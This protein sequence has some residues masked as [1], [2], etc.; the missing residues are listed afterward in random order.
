MALGRRIQ[1]AGW[2]PRGAWRC[3]A[4]CCSYLD[5]L[6]GLS[7]SPVS[8]LEPSWSDSEQREDLDRHHV[9]PQ[10]ISM[11]LAD[12]ADDCPGL[13]Q[14]P[15]TAGEA[16]QEVCELWAGLVLAWLLLLGEE[17]SHAL[18]SE[19]S[20]GLCWQQGGNSELRDR[21]RSSSASS[22]AAPTVCA[23]SCHSPFSFLVSR[24]VRE[25]GQAVLLPA[26]AGMWD[27]QL[28]LHSFL[29]GHELLPLELPEV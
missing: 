29:K 19:Q 17:H 12:G 14:L 2:M 6:N 16:G 4:L 26:G 13:F 10:G 22:P 9:V 27:L 18:C 5:L 25:L 11:S 21:G 15:S 23:L 7:L 3:S 24:K 28:S 20:C 1:S 8:K